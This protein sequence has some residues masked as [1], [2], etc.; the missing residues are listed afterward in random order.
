M[1]C[2]PERG[3]G[4]ERSPDGL[5][6][7]YKSEG[8][9]GLYRGTT[10]ALVGVSNGAIQFMGYEKMKN[11]G[12]DTMPRS[13]TYWIDY[14]VR[15]LASLGLSHHDLVPRNVLVDDNGVIFSIIDWDTSTPHHTGGEYARRIR[16]VSPNFIDPGEK[17]WYHILLRHCFD[18][19]G[20]EILIGC[21]QG[22]PKKRLQWPLV[23]SR[24]SQLVSAPVTDPRNQS[25]SVR[26]LAS[27]KY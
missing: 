3:E 19:T 13:V 25:F 10:L 22:H 7:V 17:D 21:S 12:F 6:S 2:L 24:A 4:T 9:R 1:G 18:R 11:W 16:Y 26:Q 8:I 27:E 14:I 15:E 20:E 5:S 23:K